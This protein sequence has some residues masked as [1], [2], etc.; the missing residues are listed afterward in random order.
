M[1][2]RFSLTGLAFL[3]FDSGSPLRTLS[4]QRSLRLGGRLSLRR[5]W[6]SPYAICGSIFPQADEEIQTKK[7][8]IINRSR[9]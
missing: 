2:G 7:V 8:Q 9:L 4:G 1:G 3:A 6:K 5:K